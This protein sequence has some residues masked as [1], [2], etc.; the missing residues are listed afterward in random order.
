MP[1]SRGRKK[2]KTQ[3]VKLPPRVMGILEEQRRA[4]GKKFGR[5]PVKGDPLFFDTDAGQPVEMSPVAMNAEMLEAMRKAGHPQ[6]G[7]SAR[8]PH[9]HH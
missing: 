9:R 1:K 6:K 4:F 3:V 8:L 7:A 2:S 5:D